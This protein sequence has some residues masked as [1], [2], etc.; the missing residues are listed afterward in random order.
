MKKRL[1][2]LILS[3]SVLLPSIFIV[4][5][6]AYSTSYPEAIQLYVGT[7]QDGY[8]SSY[9]SYSSNDINNLLSAS[10]EF[11]INSGNATYN[12]YNPNGS[13]KKIISTSDIDN[14]QAS[15]IAYPNKLDSI[16]NEYK[17]KLNNFSSSVTLNKLVD[18]EVALANSIINEDSNA[19]IWFSFP[20]IYFASCAT[21]YEDALTWY[22]DELK[23]SIG[24]SKWNNNVRGFYWGT[25][26]VGQYYTA[27]NTSSPSTYYDNQMIQLM[28]EMGSYIGN[29]A[30]GYKEF[31]WM[32][33]TPSDS[34]VG[35]INTTYSY[36]RGG[37]VANK[38]NIFDYVL[39]QP[40]Y[41]FHSYKYTALG[42]VLSSVQNN[43]VYNLSGSVIGG[44]KTS[45]T[46]IGVVM[47]IDSNIAGS[48]SG[49][50]DRYYEYTIRFDD[51]QPV[52]FYAG[53]RNST[54]NSTVFYYVNN[55]LN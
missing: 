10:N 14:I 37:Y 9:A 15:D 32:P 2:T 6:S 35:N 16:K 12:Y 24:T 28:A 4:P 5:A 34:E 45:N 33:Y 49:Y 17:N 42:K 3:V 13:T 20:H 46:R 7:T 21:S 31:L 29:S 36:I 8:W 23:S 47:E 11:V 19:T 53:D 38:T 1:F 26:A 25:E 27:F 22:V 18:A 40:G 54:M 41:Y 51:S 50:N 48:N 55:F 39:L 52:C 43:K 44:S 30:Q